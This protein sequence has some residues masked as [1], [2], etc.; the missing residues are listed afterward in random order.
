MKKKIILMVSF[1]MLLLAACGNNGDAGAGNAT[2][3]D[4]QEAP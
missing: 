1:I 2:G 3:T 4:A